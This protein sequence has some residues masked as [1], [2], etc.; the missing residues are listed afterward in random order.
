MNTNEQPDE[1]VL[2]AKSGKDPSVGASDPREFGF[3]TNPEALQTLS[4]R[5]FVKVPFCKHD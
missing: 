5:G 3:F 4:F 1:E 2:M